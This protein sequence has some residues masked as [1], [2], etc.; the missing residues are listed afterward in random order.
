MQRMFEAHY[1]SQRQGITEL[2]ARRLIE[3]R[4]NIRARLALSRRH[5]LQEFTQRQ[6]SENSGE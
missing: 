1:L 6:K 2:Q 5:A 3:S 4:A